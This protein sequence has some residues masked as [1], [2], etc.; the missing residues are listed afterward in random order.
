[1]NKKRT[2]VSLPSNGI[3]YRIFICLLCSTLLISACGCRLFRGR[4]VVQAPVVTRS[5]LVAPIKNLSGF[6]ELDTLSAT[7]EFVTELQMVNGLQVV[8]VNAVLSKMLALGMDTV[9]GPNDAQTLAD[10]LGV[11]GA[12][13]I[14]ISRYEPYMPPIIGIAAQLYMA[15]DVGSAQGGPDKFIDPAVLARQGRP[16]DLGM[17]RRIAAQAQTVKVYDA[18]QDDVIDAIK[19]YAKARSVQA[20]PLGWK[21]YMTQSNYMRFVSRQIIAELG[22]KK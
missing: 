4:K 12:I 17:N 8:S 6:T 7:D 5:I 15:E 22:L 1:M 13:V 20:S 11:D 9:T 14:A 2:K 3:S 19:K 18:N 16:F 21:K 10:A